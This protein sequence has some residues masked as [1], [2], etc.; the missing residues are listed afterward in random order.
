MWNDRVVYSS[1]FWFRSAQYNTLRKE[2]RQDV[3]FYQVWFSLLLIGIDSNV[4]L[5]IFGMENWDIEFFY[6]HLGVDFVESLHWEFNRALLIFCINN[7]Q[8]YVNL[9]QI[10][11][12]PQYLV[13]VRV[14]CKEICVT[15]DK[16]K[17]AYI[18]LKSVEFFLD[19]CRWYFP[20]MWNDF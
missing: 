10:G 5:Q 13:Q 20:S 16:A 9:R 1:L 15:V 4:S 18:C 11:A 19:A 14:I 3:N 7:C 8:S 12:S 2:E 6:W 17:L